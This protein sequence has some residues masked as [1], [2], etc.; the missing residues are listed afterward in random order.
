MV[1][2]DKLLKQ[3][4]WTGEEL[5]IIEITNFLEAAHRALEGDIDA[6]PRLSKSELRKMMNSL[7]RSEGMHSF[8]QS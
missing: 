5:G 2:I 6:Q 3:K 8:L 1:N 4:G 7:D